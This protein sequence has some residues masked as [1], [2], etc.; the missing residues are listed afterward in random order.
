MQ[1]PSPYLMAQLSIRAEELCARHPPKFA[2]S[3]KRLLHELACPADVPHQGVLHFSRWQERN[4]P[5]LL[6]WNEQSPRL[7]IVPGF[8]RYDS[9]DSEKEEI[10]W[11]VN[12]ADPNLFFGY[13]SSLF[14]Q[15]EVQVAE[16]PALASLREALLAQGLPARTEEGG[17]ATPV[18]IMGVERRCQVATEPDIMAGRPAGLYGRAFASASDAVIRRAL[19]SFARPSKTNIVAMAAPPPGRGKYE[20][21]TIRR[22]LVT[23]YSAFSAALELAQGSS[24]AVRRTVIHTGHWGCG[25]FGGNRVLMAKLQMLAARLAGVAEVHFHAGAGPGLLAAEDATRGIDEAPGTGT[26]VSVEGVIR[27]LAAADYSWGVSDGN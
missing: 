10:H 13:G 3:R 7:R 19:T 4:L 14:A 12:F 11:H 2:C 1:Q 5:E 17:R 16:H 8:Y 27:R 15:D 24:G 6:D 18:L 21:P 22:V 20:A 9:D 25:A 26:V 23:A